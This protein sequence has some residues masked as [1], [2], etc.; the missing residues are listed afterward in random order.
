MDIL[1][2]RKVPGKYSKKAQLIDFVEKS[3]ARPK[4]RDAIFVLK[5]YILRI[6]REIFLVCNII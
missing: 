6:C 3:T 2:S 5:R 1:S 4:F